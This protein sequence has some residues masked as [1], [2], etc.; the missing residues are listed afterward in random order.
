MHKILRV[1]KMTRY[2][3]AEVPPRQRAGRASQMEAAATDK[4]R[5]DRATEKPEQATV[6]ERRWQ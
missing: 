6:W 5:T 1:Q 3:E 4:L 2:K